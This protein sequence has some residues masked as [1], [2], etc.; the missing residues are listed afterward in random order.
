MLGRTAAIVTGIGES[1]DPID[2][3]PAFDAV[4]VFPDG[5]CPTAAVYQS[6]DAA[7]GSQTKPI[8]NQ[9]HTQWR[10]PGRLPDA[11]NDLTQAA[12]QICP[13]ITAAIQAITP[14]GYE[15]RLTGS[16]SCVFAIV[17]TKH[18][19]IAIAEILS[20]QDLNA[21]PA[22]YPKPLEPS[23]SYMI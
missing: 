3:L 14:L 1:I 11:H 17:K 20:Q 7:L 9:L 12:T 22:S 4:L 8:P 15:P 2:T 16:G 13:A 6:L 10:E 21:C 19:A 23:I 18:Q 5:T